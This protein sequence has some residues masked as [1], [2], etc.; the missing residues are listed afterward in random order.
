MSDR[1]TVR[2]EE[3]LAILRR[4]DQFCPCWWVARQLGTGSYAASAALRGLRR[5]GLVSW[6]RTDR[7]GQPTTEWL[8]GG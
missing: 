4:A 2:E 1:L 8:W 5:R 6:R 3:V 7:W